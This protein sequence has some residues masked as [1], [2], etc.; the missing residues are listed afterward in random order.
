MCNEKGNVKMLR[1]PKQEK[2][3]LAKSIRNSHKLYG[4]SITELVEKYGYCYSFTARIIR[5]D[6]L[7][8]ETY[9]APKSCKLF[10]TDARAAAC[11]ML[12]RLGFPQAEIGKVFGITQPGV[13]NLLKRDT[14][15]SGCRNVKVRLTEKVLFFDDGEHTLRKNDVVSLRKLDEQFERLTLIYNE[16]YYIIPTAQLINKV[17]I[18]NEETNP[19]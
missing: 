9:D 6:F 2:Q 4:L 10:V 1:L 12:A 7:L 3:A 8:D 11:K 15:K 17:H 16:K 5:G 13:S 19:E 14:T 18:H